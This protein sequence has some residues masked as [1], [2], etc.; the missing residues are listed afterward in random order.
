M[1]ERCRTAGRYD[2]IARTAFV[3]QNDQLKP[4]HQRIFSIMQTVYP[5]GTISGRKQIQSFLFVFGLTNSQIMMEF[6]V[7]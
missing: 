2:A 4:A 3:A 7:F 6:E 1:D 5:D